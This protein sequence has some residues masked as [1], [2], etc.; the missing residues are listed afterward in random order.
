VVVFMKVSFRAV[1]QRNIACSNGPGAEL[2][3]DIPFDSR[4]DAVIKIDFLR[5]RYTAPFT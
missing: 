2:Q 3:L 1:K 5:L 4:Q